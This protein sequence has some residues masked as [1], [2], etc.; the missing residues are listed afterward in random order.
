MSLAS[1]ALIAAAIFMVYA[2]LTAR[3]AALMVSVLG[4][5][6]VTGWIIH[7]ELSMLIA[8]L[9]LGIALGVAGLS[10]V[11]HRALSSQDDMVG[12]ISHEMITNN[13]SATEN[14]GSSPYC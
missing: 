8:A 11:I 5:A 10:V 12:H 6:A 14:V 9:G 1:I 7:S 4:Y 3:Q 13:R 2:I